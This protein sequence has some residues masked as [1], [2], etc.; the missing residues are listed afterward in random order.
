M[1][2]WSSRRNRNCCASGWC[3]MKRFR[4]CS[5]GTGGPCFKGVDEG[6]WRDSADRCGES[7]GGLV[8]PNQPYSVSVRR[9]LGGV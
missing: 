7:I 9:S 8:T 6:V 1:K 2:P 4:K 5:M 3:D